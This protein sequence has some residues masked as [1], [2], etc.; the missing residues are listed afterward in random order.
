MIQRI[1]DFAFYANLPQEFKDQLQSGGVDIRGLIELILTSRGFD[2]GSLPKGLIPFHSY[3]GVWKNP[4]QEHLEQGRLIGTDGSSFHFTI[5]KDYEADILTSLDY[6]QNVLNQNFKL[7]FSEQDSNTDSFAFGENMTPM[8]GEN[9]VPITRPAGHGAL[10]NNLDA[11]DSDLIFI[12]NIDNIQH[13]NKSENSIN[14]R[15]CLGAALLEFQEKVF[16]ILESIKEGE[17]VTADVAKL[18]ADYDLRMPEEAMKHASAARDFLN[19]PIRICGMVK[20]EGQPGGGPFWVEDNGQLSRQIVEKAQISQE[21]GQLDI[22]IKSTH[23]N[24]VELICGVR[25]YKGKKFDLSDFVNPDLY[26]IVSKTH[27]G[28]DIRYVEQPG[29]WNGGM[30][31]WITLFYE[32]DT[33]CFS[34]V[35]TVL[36]LLGDLHRP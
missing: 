11:L 4:F 5:N 20:N 9:G 23:F 7:S 33:D 29:L 34:P 36:D 19:R 35:K 32:I 2:Y 3:D 21:S 14:Y 27:E 24:P 1:K 13:G 6:L 25:D 16:R 26:F 30:A 8:K 17:S 10:L 28:N 31:N 22:L 15:K 12:R 18:N